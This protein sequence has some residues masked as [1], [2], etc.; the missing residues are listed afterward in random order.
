MRCLINADKSDV[1]ESANL[2]TEYGDNRDTPSGNSDYCGPEAG[3]NC[4]HLL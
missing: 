4:T 2:L 1:A 3:Q